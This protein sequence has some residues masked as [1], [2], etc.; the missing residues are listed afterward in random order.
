MVDGTP[1]WPIDPNAKKLC[2]TDQSCADMLSEDF[3][4]AK[5]GNVFL[6]YGLDPRVVDKTDQIELINNDIVNFNHIGNAA[7]VVFQS[8]TLEGWTQLMHNYMDSYNKWVTVSFFLLV[9]VLGAF[10]SMNL[11]L[12]QIMHSFISQEKKEKEQEGELL[13]QKNLEQ[14]ESN[15]QQTEEKTT[16]ARNLFQ[17]SSVK[18]NEEKKLKE[19]SDEFSE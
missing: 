14:F 19:S 15:K 2:Q 18:K 4:V 3:T 9:I 7:V 6:E 13:F 12:A 8:L 17:L 1:F 11:F 5:C 16:S 10:V